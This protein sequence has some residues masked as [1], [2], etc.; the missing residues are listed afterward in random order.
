MEVI[1]ILSVNGMDT[2]YFYLQGPE[3]ERRLSTG[4]PIVCNAVSVAEGILDGK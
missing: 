2:A 1:Q 3:D 4:E